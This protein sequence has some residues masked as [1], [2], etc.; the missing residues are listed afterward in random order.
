MVGS[1]ELRGPYVVEA[2][3]AYGGMAE[4]TLGFSAEAVVQ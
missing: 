3:Q 4:L 2:L 1:A